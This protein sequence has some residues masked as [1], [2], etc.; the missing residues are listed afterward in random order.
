MITCT[1]RYII[2]IESMYRRRYCSI[3]GVTPEYTRH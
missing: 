1:L 3:F 2:D